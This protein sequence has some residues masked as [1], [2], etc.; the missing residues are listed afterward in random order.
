M[1]VIEMTRKLG[2][3]IQ[4]DPRY[5]TM[6]AAKAA[7]DT[8]EE[9]QA[10]S[11]EMDSLQTQFNMLQMEQSTDEAQ[12]EKLSKDFELKYRE[13]MANDTMAAYNVARG[14][15]DSLMNDVMQIL[16]LSVNGEDPMTAQ[17]SEEL[18][19]AMQSGQLA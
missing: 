1:D 6:Q 17:P 9:L 10:I 11:A 2:V 18:L 16:Y 19:Q 7:I 5:K 4:E 12:I 15:V 3:T 13:L 8:D 14:E